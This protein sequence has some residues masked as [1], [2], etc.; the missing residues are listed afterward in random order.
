MRVCI[1]YRRFHFCKTSNSGTFLKSK[2]ISCSSSK[3]YFIYIIYFSFHFSFF[4]IPKILLIINHC[5]FFLINS[6]LNTVFLFWF[7]SRTIRILSRISSYFVGLVH[8]WKTRSINERI[9]SMRTFAR[10]PSPAIQ[11][12]GYCRSVFKQHSDK[13]RQICRFC[14]FLHCILIGYLFPC[15]LS[16]FRNLHH[17]PGSNC[18]V[19]TAHWTVEAFVE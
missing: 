11:T 9:Y 13:W 18:L 19:S 7:S 8:M 16:A 15:F 4:T 1:F 6:I 3:F 14:H 2:F 12:A 17:F 10:I 5:N